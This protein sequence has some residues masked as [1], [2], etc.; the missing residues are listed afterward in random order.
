MNYT[1]KKI[2][3][4]NK[5][6][7]RIDFRYYAYSDNLVNQGLIGR[8]KRVKILASKKNK[9]QVETHAN[10]IISQSNP[11]YDNGIFLIKEFFG[12]GKL[13]HDP[14]SNQGQKKLIPND[15]DP[16]LG[17]WYAKT[18][19]ND[20]RTFNKPSLKTLEFEF[21]ALKKF[22]EIAGH[23]EFDKL[24]VD[25]FARD[26]YRNIQEG[27][28]EWDEISHKA[29]KYTTYK[30]YLTTIKMACRKLSKKYKKRDIW[31]HFEPIPEPSKEESKNSKALRVT[32]EHIKYVYEAMLKQYFV[33][34]Q[35]RGKEIA[36]YRTNKI[37]LQWR[38][39]S[40]T[41]CRRNE[42]TGLTWD[43]IVLD[44]NGL[45]EIKITQQ[46]HSVENKLTELKNR[47]K[48]DKI[49]SE[50]LYKDLMDYKKSMP[51]IEKKNNIVFPNTFGEFDKRNS[52]YRTLNNTNKNLFGSLSEGGDKWLRVHDIRHYF[53]T[54]LIR[55]GISLADVSQLLGHSNE[56]VTASIYVQDYK[57]T[58]ES[59]SNVRAAL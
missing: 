9:S 14:Q 21:C 7:W 26:L 43:K 11:D 44:Q 58:D 5:D 27:G 29:R 48:C 35:N 45:P 53:A 41:G 39:Y 30:K 31:E 22:V 56:Q 51:L 38:F 55:K 1:I 12:V 10:K 33:G 4:K 42:L 8:S 20:Y 46:F 36:V 28:F 37:D 47:K 57:L 2:N 15:Q 23:Q 40:E 16:S 13:V 50:Q 6:Y 3:E 18:R 59:K 17:Y 52:L 32:D 24:D 54:R 34:N 19:F 49:I 25:T